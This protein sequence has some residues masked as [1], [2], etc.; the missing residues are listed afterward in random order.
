MM[1]QRPAVHRARAT[2]LARLTL[3][4]LLAG[5]AGC[6]PRTDVPPVRAADTVVV[7]ATRIGQTLP[8]LTFATFSGD[9][10]TVGGL[11]RQPVT[12]LNLWSTYCGPCIEEFPLVERLHQEYG[13]R[14]LRVL[15]V[16]VD[17]LDGA[18]SNFL[19]SHPV[20]LRIARDPAGLS[21][22]AL[23]NTALPQNVL[24]SADGRVL[25]RGGAFGT[26]LPAT[27]LAV[28]ESALAVS[29]AV[30]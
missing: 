12:L 21:T 27:C 13:P 25:Y 15:A 17:K 3:A 30:M 11:A 16:S 9:S 8:Q 29:A 18:V 20:T 19:M 24:V 26:E 2:L 5:L 1:S 6:A 23:A 28:I 22:E 7:E 4:T 14:G 10:A